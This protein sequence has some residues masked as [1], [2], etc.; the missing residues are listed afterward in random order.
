MDN[1][2]ERGREAENENLRIPDEPGKPPRP[3]TEPPGAEWSMQSSETATDPGSGEPIGKAGG[4]RP[5]GGSRWGRVSR[6][7]KQSRG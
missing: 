4:R 7:F 5:P 2:R 1:S 6:F 3:A